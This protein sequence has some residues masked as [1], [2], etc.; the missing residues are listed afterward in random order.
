VAKSILNKKTH[1]KKTKY[2]LYY[3]Q[4]TTLAGRT[5]RRYL[6]VRF[7]QFPS[8]GVKVAPSAFG[9]ALS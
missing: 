5:R 6:V 8:G 7:S 3:L 4:L 1:K 2:M 9:V